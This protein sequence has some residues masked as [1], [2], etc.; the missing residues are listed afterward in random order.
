MLAPHV[1]QLNVS[2]LDPVKVWSA[3]E[4]YAN[5]IWER[6]V[7][8]YENMRVVYQIETRLKQ[9]NEEAAAAAAD[10]PEGKTPGEQK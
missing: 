4:N 8:S 5:R 1:R 3:A 6:G 7:K 2:D 10:V 9:W